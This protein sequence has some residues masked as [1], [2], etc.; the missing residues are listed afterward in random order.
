MRAL[1]NVLMGL[2][3]LFMFAALPVA[4]ATIELTEKD[5]G[6]VIKVQPGDQIKVTVPCN[7]TTGYWPSC[8]F[9]I[10][11]NMKR[12]PKEFSDYLTDMVD[13][14]DKASNFLHGVSLKSFKANEEKELAVIR[15]LEA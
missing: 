14:A 15:S 1:M 3:G 10:G 6:A 7:P 8:S 2:L 5:N 13:Y 11:T 9:R 12:P 4:A